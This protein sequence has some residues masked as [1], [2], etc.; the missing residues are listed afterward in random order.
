MPIPQEN[1]LF[2]EQARCLLLTMVQDVRSTSQ[3]YSW[4]AVRHSSEGF[5]F[6]TKGQRREKKFGFHD[7]NSDRHCRDSSQAKTSY[8][9]VKID[10]H[11]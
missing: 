5:C 11:K 2:V 1:S 9:Y 8:N 10:E 7:L 6:L 4:E 3:A